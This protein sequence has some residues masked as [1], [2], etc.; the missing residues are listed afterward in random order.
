VIGWKHWLA[1]I[2]FV[3]LLFVVA[4]YSGVFMHGD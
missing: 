1:A 2:A 4:F 3:V